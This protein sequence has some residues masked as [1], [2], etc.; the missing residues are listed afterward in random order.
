MKNV[1]VLDVTPCGSCENRRFGG[2]YRLHQQRDKN[3]L[4][5]A[6]VVPSSPMLVT[7]MMKLL[8]SSETPVLTRATRINMPE[9]GILQ[10]ISVLL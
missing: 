5:P 8:R 7:L 4:L 10:K 1:V 3:Q 2:T 6:N 9:D